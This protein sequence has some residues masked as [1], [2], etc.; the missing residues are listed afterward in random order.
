MTAKDSQVPWTDE[1]W[2]RVDQVVQDE[3]S[4]ARVGDLPAIVRAAS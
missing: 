1:Q 2:A 4:R 3:A